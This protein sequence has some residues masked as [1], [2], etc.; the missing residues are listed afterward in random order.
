MIAKP[1]ADWL[2]KSVYSDMQSSSKIFAL[3]F[4]LKDQMPCFNLL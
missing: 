1:I 3:N 2:I 4:G